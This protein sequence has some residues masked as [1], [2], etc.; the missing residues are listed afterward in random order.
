[1]VDARTLN[2]STSASSALYAGVL[3]NTYLLLSLTLV[4][5]T[6]TAYVSM[7]MNTQPMGFGMLIIYIGLLFAVTKTQN[8]VWG[9]FWV[10]ALTGFLG[11]TLGPIL[12]YSSSALIVQSL[13]LTAA[14]FVALSAYALITRKDFSFLSGFLIAGAVIILGLVVL[15]L[16]I[17][18]SAFSMAIS[19]GMVLFASALILFQTSQIVH[20]GE[21]NY[22]SATVGLYV[23]LYSLFI[24]LLSLLG[25]MG[26]D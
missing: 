22:I 12:N 25:I 8:S 5:S 26:D 6:V 11:F 2:P 9:L 23:A 17:D 21:T 20:G 10:F 7:Q 19:G 24:H 13:G 15:S 1:M 16:F 18:M 3:R 14:V 4:W